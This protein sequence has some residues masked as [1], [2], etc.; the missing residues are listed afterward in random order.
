MKS[1]FTKPGAIDQWKGYVTRT[2]RESW[3]ERPLTR[4]I[5]QEPNEYNTAP[6]DA[7]QID[8]VTELLPAVGYENIVTAMGVFSC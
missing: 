2:I 4:P 6:E 5:L 3:I 1:N 7:M 8:L